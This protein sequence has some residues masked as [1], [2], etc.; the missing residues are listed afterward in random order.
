[1]IFITIL[2]IL[3]LFANDIRLVW[4]PKKFD[5]YVDA[6]ILFIFVTF[7]FELII[8]CLAKHNYI[9]S[10]FFILDFIAISSLFL[11]IYFILEL[12]F[13]EKSSY[14]HIPEQANLIT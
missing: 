9:C 11:D 2:T 6:L 3:A 10:F 1:M 12:V 14:V 7:M 8:S 5:I 13:V 4:I